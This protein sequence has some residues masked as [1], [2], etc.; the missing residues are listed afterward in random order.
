MHFR[1]RRFQ[2][3]TPR[4]VNMGERIYAVYWDECYD[5]GFIFCVCSQEA[6]DRRDFEREMQMRAE[7]DEMMR[8]K[9]V[10]DGHLG[11]EYE[12]MAS[13]LAWVRKHFERASLQPGYD[14]PSFEA[15]NI[16]LRHAL[17]N[18]EREIEHAIDAADL[19]MDMEI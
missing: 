9:T 7:H 5:C 3:L 19:A 11:N 18:L 8:P 2:D 15:V 6:L 14:L 4:C 10:G 13:N 1:A 17:M 16:N 12:N